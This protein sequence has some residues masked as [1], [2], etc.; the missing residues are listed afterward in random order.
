MARDFY[1]EQTTH[2]VAVATSAVKL[3][4]ERAHAERTATLVQ[5]LGT[6][7]IYIGPSGVT[8]ASGVKVA[9]D[10]HIVI[11]GPIDLY[12]ISVGTSDVRVM[13]LQ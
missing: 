7:V 8:T 3:T 10:N 5:N 11:E 6:D 2:A 9:V 4:T 12:A 1:E 13:E